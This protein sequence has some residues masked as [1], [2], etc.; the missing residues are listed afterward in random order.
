MKKRVITS[1]VEFQT[2]LQEL[3][4][5]REGL[6]YRGQ[7][8]SDWPVSCAAAR[9]LAKDPAD[10]LEIQGVSIRTLVGYLE[11]LT[12][13]ARMRGFLP[14]G[15]RE[16]STSLELLGQLQHQGAATGLI[17]FTRQPLVALWFAC[18]ES[19]S[20]DGAV[21]VLPSSTT[22][23][24][25][26][27]KDLKKEI[28]SLYGEDTIWS[29]EPT[30]VGSRIVA[31]SSVFVLGIPLIGPDKLEQ[32]IVQRE[33]KREILSQLENVYGIT[34]ETLYLD[35]PGYAVANGFDKNFD[36]RHTMSYWLEQIELAVSD[37][38]KAEAYKN[39]GLAFEDIND[40]TNAS[41]QYAA[42]RSI[43]EYLERK[44]ELEESK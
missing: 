18:D 16:D 7:P 34:E 25:S 24:L 39:C 5:E 3:T 27:H 36:S 38:E 1:L 19:Q 10:P 17:D 42:E 2:V 9:R 4:H 22:E 23:W 44:N 32:V 43:R 15:F 28:R 40:P 11:F 37:E 8:K 29:W 14:S 13:R 26:R 30:V 33:S 21:Y 41:K 12:A 31:Q 20:D 6:L 35:F